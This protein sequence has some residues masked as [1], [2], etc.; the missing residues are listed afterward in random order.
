M[1]TELARPGW[2]AKPFF[3]VAALL[4]ACCPSLSASDG[5]PKFQWNRVPLYAHLA[6]GDG[7]EPKQIEF[8][9][10]HFSVIALTGGTVTK[11]SVEYG[12]FD[13]YPEFDKKLGAP[14]DDAKRE[15]FTYTREFEHASVFVNVE[16]KTGRID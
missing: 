2:F 7:L 4:I 3:V 15:G 14:K 11:G 12:T 8:L 16:K 6:V 9:A 5:Y 10:D 13:W 1:S